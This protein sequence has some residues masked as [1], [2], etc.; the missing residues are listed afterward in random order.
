MLHFSPSWV[1]VLHLGSSSSSKF[2]H[3]TPSLTHT[4]VGS[5]YNIY[6]NEI[7]RKLERQH[8]LR[9]C[10]DSYNISDLHLH[11]EFFSCTLRKRKSL[12]NI[13]RHVIVIKEEQ[14][15][16]YTRQEGVGGPINKWWSFITKGPSTTL[17][18]CPDRRSHFCPD[19]VKTYLV[20]TQLFWGEI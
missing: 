11:R 4:Q 1:G 5:I 3:I 19:M 7:E 20:K 10:V 8:L 16:I 12:I 6:K 9:L 14:I 13:Y 15:T 2:T 17:K 18:D